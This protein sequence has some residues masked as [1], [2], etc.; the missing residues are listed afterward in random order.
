M[1]ETTDYGFYLVATDT[2]DG[3][4]LYRNWLRR[5]IDR[6]NFVC[7]GNDAWGYLLYKRRFHSLL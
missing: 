5:E 6:G 4:P 7:V 3:Q 1:S 2:A